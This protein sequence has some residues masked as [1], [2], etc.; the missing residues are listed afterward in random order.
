MFVGAETV[1]VREKF[2]RQLAQRD[3]GCWEWLGARDR[4]GYGIFSHRSQHSLAHRTAWSLFKSEPLPSGKLLRTC[5]RT[6]CCNPEHLVAKKGTQSIAVTSDE[7]FDRATPEPNTGCWLWARVWVD[8]DGYGMLKHEGRVWRAHRL[9][10]HLTRGPIGDLCVLHHCDTPACIN[11]DHLFL[12]TNVDNTAD[13]HRKGRD[14]KGDRNGSR[15][16][17][18][19]R[20]RGEANPKA[21][22]TAAKVVELRAAYASGV[23]QADL[24]R[25]YGVRPNAVRQIILGRHWS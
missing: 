6:W 12:G 18:E 7:L 21:K 13:R 5:D 8:A 9:A 22:L 11:P 15:L 10:W 1:D 16:H 14:A 19:T 3:D 20:P 24:A 4:S 25:R 2:M 17:P 23:C